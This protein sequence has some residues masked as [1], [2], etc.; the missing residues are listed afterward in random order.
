MTQSDS[1][2]VDPSRP[3]LVGT[4]GSPDS[5]AA[6]AWAAQAAA[7]RG[8]PLQVLHCLDHETILTS[9]ISRREL[10]EYAEALAA[11][12]AQEA[13]A[14]QPEIEV[15]SEV[16]VGPPAQV[17][18]DAADRA[19]LLVLGRRGGGGF[20][21][22]L[23]GSTSTA[24]AYRTRTPLVVVPGDWKPADQPR[25]IVVGVDSSPENVRAVQA[26]FEAAESAGSTLHA[27]RGW[28]MS[29]IFA[30]DMADVV[31]GFDRYEEEARQ[32]L[33]ESLRP[34]QVR[35]PDVTVEQEVVR[36]HAVDVVV[37][38]SEGAGLV[39]IGAHGHKR[40][41]GT[42]LGSV[43]R[44]VLHHAKAPVAVVPSG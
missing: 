24:A 22:M 14:A 7:I 18:V 40:L 3:V 19:Q 1:P 16:R 27:V 25:P 13:R 4:D 44:G 41:R 34:W 39:V 8:V 42:S 23:M 9:R 29:P 5:G 32:Q 15:S 11:R 2:A 26:A 6:I 36:G 17:L 43:T 10:D 37:E 38:A 28:E 21:R 30:G 20:R 12:S 31:G 33:A 35:F